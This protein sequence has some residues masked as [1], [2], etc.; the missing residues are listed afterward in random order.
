MIWINEP[1]IRANAIGTVG[2]EV[3]YH[4]Y[5]I[6]LAV[7]EAVFLLFIWNPGL[8]RYVSPMSRRIIPSC[9]GIILTAVIAI[10]GFFVIAPLLHDGLEM[11]FLGWASGPLV[12][13]LGYWLYSAFSLLYVPL[14]FVAITSPAGPEQGLRSLRKI[15]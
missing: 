5:M 9:L 8:G 12:N 14:F 4:A 15:L 2:F 1:A 7:P 3:T 6:G 10:V 11:F 13:V